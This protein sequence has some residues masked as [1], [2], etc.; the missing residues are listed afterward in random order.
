MALNFFK[1]RDI[2]EMDINNIPED[3][4]NYLDSLDDEDKIVML[5]SRPDIAQKLGVISGDADSVFVE[6]TISANEESLVADLKDDE[7]S[8]DNV[9]GD[10]EAQEKEIGSDQDEFAEISHNLYAGQDMHK[11][12]QN[13]MR[14]LEALAISDHATKCLLHNV[15]FDEI[16]IKY[17][18]GTTYGIVLRVCHQCHRAYMKESSME[19]IHGVLSKRNIP[20]TFY[21]LDLTNR[22]LRSQLEEHEMALQEKVFV[23]ENWNKDRPLCPIHEE[24][25]FEMPCCRTYKDRKVTFT[26]YY[27]EQCGKI[28]IR[29][30]YAID[31]EDECAKNGVPV[32]EHEPLIK[33]KPKKHQ[34]PVKE[35]KPEYIIEEG[36]RLSYQY[37][38]TANCYKLT[39]ADTVVVSDS[40]YCNLSGH[41]TDEVLA[42]IMLQ[43]KNG[44]KKAYMFMVGYCSQCQKYYMDVEDYKVAYRYGRLE[45]TI[46]SD[47]DDTDFMITSGEVFDLER[48]HLEKVEHDIDTSI[49]A[50]MNSADYVSP[51][52]TD[53]DGSLGGGGLAFAKSASKAKYGKKLDELDSYVSRPYAYRV[54]ISADGETETYY[55]GAT[56]VVLNDEKVVISANSDFGYELINYQTIDVQHNGKKYAIKLSRQFEID[57]AMLYGYQNLRTDED[58]I[59]K[60]G[61]TDPF[62]VRVLNMRKRQHNLTDIFVT[63]QENQNKIV[64]AP[65]EQNMIV[66]GCAGSGK[67]MVLLH[68]LSRL[69]YQQK[70]FDFAK[71]AMILTPN[72]QFSLHIKGLAE[73]LQIGNIA[74]VSVEQ[75][76]IDM[77]VEYDSVFKPDNK[78]VSEMLVRQDFVDYI[79]SDQFAAK[80][81][82]IYDKVISER[83]ALTE[84]VDN[85]ADAMGEERRT[86]SIDDDSRVMQQMQFAVEAL[87]TIVKMHDQKI[88]HAKNEL[89][90]VISRKQFLETQLPEKEKTA[91]GIVNEAVPRVAE[92]IRRYLE[93]KQKAIS[94]LQEQM[95]RAT[96]ELNKVQSTIIMFGKKARIEQLENEII[97]IQKKINSATN[98][99]EAEIVVLKMPLNGK[100]EDEL[101]DWM[102]QVALYIKECQDDVRLCK[103]TKQEY[104]N[105]VSEMHEIGSEIE[106]AQEKFQQLEMS[107]YNTEVRN[108]IKYLYEKID[109]YSV[110][111]TYQMVFEET[112][113]DFK[114]AHQIG[115]IVGKCH[116]FD[117]YAQL[118]FAMKYYKRVNGSVQFIC[119]DEGQDVAINEYRLISRL[120]QR[121]VVFNIFGD[122]NQLIKPG[123]GISDWSVIENELSASKFVLNENYRNTNQITKLCN[124]CFE[125]D[126]LQTGVDGSGV[127]EISRS[128]LEKELSVWSD[129]TERVA[130]LLPRG[131][132]KK[133]YL[134]TELLSE[135]IQNSIGEEM[136]AGK[137]AVMYVDEVKGIEFDR[138]FVVENKMSRNE[139]YIA[140]TRALSDLIV[141][142]DDNIPDYDDGSDKSDTLLKEKHERKQSDKKDNVFKWTGDA[143]GASKI[144][145]EQE[146]TV[147]ERHTLIDKT[148]ESVPITLALLR[149]IHES[150]II[151]ATYSSPG[152][153]GRPGEIVLIAVENDTMNLYR[154]NYVAHPRIGDAI[155]KMFGSIFSQNTVEWSSMRMGMGNNLVLRSEL[156]DA[157]IEKL[158]ASEKHIYPAHIQ[159]LYQIAKEKL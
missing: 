63:I 101:I 18:K 111:G 123:R 9:P 126:V 31:L 81:V 129:R 25:L 73:G 12:L 70:S 17:T 107:K 36:K 89:D 62:L 149:E 76:Y 117:L 86:I 157:F 10:L 40:I 66:Q 2:D 21:N 119:V 16:Q 43:E 155:M 93:E 45:T 97:E 57:H 67:T 130:V 147:M 148:R 65:F 13:D 128:E 88:L 142:V 35:I 54:D 74:R 52:A 48:K 131:V 152:A 53:M 39:E 139:K 68:R 122:T 118:I 33:K 150:N 159:I 104:S 8:I 28:L 137:I 14:P 30:A 124:T 19:Y 94:E 135:D 114:K 153:M 11:V 109:T 125:M 60:N 90:K 61:I 27:C 23:P 79:Y 6:E 98:K 22:Y 95:D 83:N 100:S 34:I 85:L 75:Y 37:N 80:F 154:C 151:A 146:T 44:S 29:K 108:A 84:I 7:G 78:V 133:Q 127:R 51:Y 46:I 15:P 156:Q 42:L 91:A 102:S 49:K 113:H 158:E 77:L 58:M 69:K 20:H 3:F 121:R 136:D 140:Y 71:K 96:A 26:G 5:E 120:N 50:I 38:Y 59:F 134:H 82:S 138:V 132:Q 144:Q 99:M 141:V 55:I 103:R 105:F 72:D 106:N 64:N 47:F 110:L 87:D 145:S 1:Q 116:R 32:I 41:N 92:K 24:E 112:V 143:E 115:N 56:D 4:I